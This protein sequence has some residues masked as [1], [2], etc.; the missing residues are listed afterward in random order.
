MITPL[1]VPARG[2]DNGHYHNTDHRRLNRADYQHHRCRRRSDSAANPDVSL[3]HECPDGRRHRQSSLHA[4]EGRLLLA[5]LQTRQYSAPA[6]HDCAGDYA[7]RHLRCQSA[8]DMAC[9][10]TGLAG[11]HRKEY[12]SA[13]RGGDP[14]FTMAVY[15]ADVFPASVTGGYG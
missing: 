1:F 10:G 9:L 2:K 6:R 8:G 3:R 13:G 5:A 11:D 7:A 14:V 12:Q 4:D 15:S